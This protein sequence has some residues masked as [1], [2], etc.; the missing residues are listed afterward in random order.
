METELVVTNLNIAS[1]C[2]GS[3]FFSGRKK[4]S[5]GYQCVLGVLF[6]QRNAFLTNFSN[7]TVFLYLDLHENVAIYSFVAVFIQQS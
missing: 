7:L 1:V 5:L 3:L 4:S 2:M 6:V